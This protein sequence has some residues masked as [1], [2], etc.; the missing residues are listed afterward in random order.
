MI[1]Y[2]VF[3]ISNTRHG[4]WMSAPLNIFRKWWIG[5]NVRS[6]CE[7]YGSAEGLQ[8]ICIKNMETVDH[9]FFYSIG[10]LCR[11]CTLVFISM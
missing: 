9:F 8:L 4:I 7:N 2:V 1:T 6:D 10:Q 3:Y 11:K 5:D